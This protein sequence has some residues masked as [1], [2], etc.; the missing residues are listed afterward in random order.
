MLR[1]IQLIQSCEE[2]RKIRVCWV[3]INKLLDDIVRDQQLNIRWL[4]P[5]A[6]A[7]QGFAWWLVHAYPRQMLQG[8]W[9]LLPIALTLL[10]SLNYLHGGMR[11]LRRRQDWIVERNAQER[12]EH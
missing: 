1:S 4:M 5:L 10:F 12:M 3:T 2:K 11:M 9:H 6:V 8:R 7:Y